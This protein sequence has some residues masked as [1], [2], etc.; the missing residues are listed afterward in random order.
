MNFTQITFLD[1]HNPEQFDI[2]GITNHG[3]ML[4]IPFVNN[5]FAEVNGKRKYVRLLI[6]SIT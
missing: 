4:G 1:K 3:D 5:C 6:K 2:I